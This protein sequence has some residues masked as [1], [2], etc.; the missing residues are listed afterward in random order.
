[1]KT[2]RAIIGP[3]YGFIDQLKKY[4]K[5]IEEQDKV[6]GYD[7]VKNPFDISKYTGLPPI[8]IDKLH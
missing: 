4:S 1:V 5:E 3:N 8:D 2:Q 7:R 6:E